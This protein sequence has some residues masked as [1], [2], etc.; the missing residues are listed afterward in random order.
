[1]TGRCPA[2][3]NYSTTILRSLP[4]NRRVTLNKG[5]VLF[6]LTRPESKLDPHLAELLAA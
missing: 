3:F 2:G 4:H 5:P 6:A 1:M